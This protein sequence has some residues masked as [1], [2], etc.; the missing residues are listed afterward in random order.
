MFNG[1]H[2]EESSN[3]IGY[4][5]HTYVFQVATDFVE[6]YIFTSAL[7]GSSSVLSDSASLS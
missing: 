2:S 1:W 4:M 7:F 3:S 5:F 6:H